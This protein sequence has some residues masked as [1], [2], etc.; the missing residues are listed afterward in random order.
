MFSQDRVCLWYWPARFILKHK[1]TVK[2]NTE[3]RNN[4]KENIL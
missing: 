1:G 4:R 2:E 3:I